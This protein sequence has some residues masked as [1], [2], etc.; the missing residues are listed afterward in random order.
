[1][2]ANSKC[3]SKPRWLHG[4]ASRPAV[5]LHYKVR[6]KLY[7]PLVEE[8]VM[9]CSVSSHGETTLGEVL[10]TPQPCHSCLQ[11]EQSKSRALTHSR[12]RPRG[13]FRLSADEHATSA[14]C[15]LAGRIPAI[16]QCWH[17]C[18]MCPWVVIHCLW[19]HMGS[20]PFSCTFGLVFVPL[21]CVV[22]AV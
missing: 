1:M 10:A 20:F 11:L 6:S 8:T 12:V 4:Q 22:T 21:S 19:Y 7:P 15:V 18:N 2:T 5:N 14:S 3:R 13:V 16:L 9:I 17:V